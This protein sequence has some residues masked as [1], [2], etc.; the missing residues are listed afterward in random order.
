MAAPS[1]PRTRLS[2]SPTSLAFSVLLVPLSLCPFPRRRARAYERRRRRRQAALGS[3]SSFFFVACDFPAAERRVHDIPP[4]GWQSAARERAAPLLPQ[5]PL[6]L[7]LRSCFGENPSGGRRSSL[8][9]RA[10]GF[11]C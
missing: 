5:N 1:S 7:P 4:S 3:R 8:A 9:A 11:Y 10:A 2:R 6:V